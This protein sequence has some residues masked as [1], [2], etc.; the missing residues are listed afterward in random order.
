M[1]ISSGIPKNKITKYLYI[2]IGMISFC[3][4]IV[5]IFLPLLPTTPFLL[6]SAYLWAKSSKRLYHWLMTNKYFGKYLTEI[7][8]NKS[9]P[10]KTKIISLTIMW[11]SILYSTLVIIENHIVNGLLYL[12]TLFISYHI[13][14]FPTLKKK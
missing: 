5:G 10:I 8:E 4:G 7:R 13:I 1:N 3:L 6:L 14:K 12:S 2:I 9:I 11:S